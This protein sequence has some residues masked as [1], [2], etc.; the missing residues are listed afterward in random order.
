MPDLRSLLKH[1]VFFA[2]PLPA[3]VALL[4]LSIIKHFYQRLLLE[5]DCA[6]I[7]LAADQAQFA[8]IFDPPNVNGHNAS[9]PSHPA[10]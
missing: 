8:D 3:L 10:P 7:G 1:L 5:I 9:R 2:A 6:A 4:D